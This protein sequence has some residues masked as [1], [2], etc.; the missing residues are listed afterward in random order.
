MAKTNLQ[1]FYLSLALCGALYQM[2][3]SAAETPSET[4][5]AQVSLPHQEQVSINDA[6]AETSS[7]R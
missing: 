6:T 3:L 4:Q 7:R 2:P 5:A 1:A